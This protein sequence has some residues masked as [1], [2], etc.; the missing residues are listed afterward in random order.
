MANSL[1]RGAPV[2][3]APALPDTRVWMYRGKEARLFNSMDEIPAGED[4]RDAPYEIEQPEPEAEAPK[5][6]RKP[7]AA[8]T[9]NQDVEKTDGDGN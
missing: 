8:S 6:T 2:T 7:R 4:W 9:D 3:P 1:I 5:R